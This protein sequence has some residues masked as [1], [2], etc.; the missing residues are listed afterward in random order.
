MKPH[1]Q[2]EFRC[3]FPLPVTYDSS[4]NRLKE[5]LND[6]QGTLTKTLSF[7]YDALNRPNRVTYPD[8][9]YS[10]YSYDVLGNR[11]SL[12]DPKDNTQTYIYDSLGRLTDVIQPGG[13]TTTYGH[14]APRW[15]ASFTDGNG[16]TTTYQYDD[17]GHLYEEISPDTGSTAYQYDPAG[18]MNLKTDARGITINYHY[19]AL[20][21]LI[22]I[23]YPTE[24]DVV[25][26]Y[27]TCTNGK[28][29]LCQVI[30]QA[31]TTTFTYSLKG[32]LV[33][34]DRLI[35][36]VNYITEYQYDDNGNLEVLTYPGGRTV[37]YAYDNADQ[38]T[39]VWTIPAG[40]MQE[41]VAS[42]IT[43]KPFGPIS[44]LIYGNGLPR[45]VSYDLLY[46]VVGIQTGAIQDLTYG[47]DPNDNVETIADNLNPGNNK[48]FS[49][50]PLNRL[51]GATGPWGALSLGYDN[52]GN[53]QTYTD[54]LGTTNYTYQGGTNLLT[55]LSGATSATFTYDNAGNMKTE[56]SRQY[57]Y[58]ENGDLSNVTD[59][60]S[61][62]DYT[63][64]AS[65]QRTTKTN[66]GGTTV[67][68]YDARELLVAETLPDGTVQSEYIYLGEQPLAKAI[69]GELH[70]IHTDHLV[71]PVMMTDSSGATTWSLEKR[72]FGDGEN[73]TGSEDLDIRFPGQYVDQDSGLHYNHYRYYEPSTGRYTQPDP[74]GMRGDWTLYAYVK[75]NPLLYSDPQGLQETLPRTKPERP[76][77]EP[78]APAP[79]GGW[80]RFRECWSKPNYGT[81]WWD[82]YL[83][84]SWGKGE[85]WGEPTTPGAAGHAAA[86][87]GDKYT[88]TYW[89][90][91]DLPFKK[92]EG[93]NKF[94]EIDWPKLDPDMQYFKDWCNAKTGKTGIYRGFCSGEISFK[95]RAVICACCK[96]D[97]D[98]GKK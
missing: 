35:L 27:D 22:S 52:V 33:Q 78:N 46:R 56:N 24:T 66:S 29:R 1:F 68:H 62:G 14:D 19:D 75:S 95:G 98:K 69:G 65:S 32:E 94:G 25:Y 72:P 9:T 43:H 84:G 48:T 80:R 54:D 81:S 41:A 31:G 23:D 47:R 17:T 51:V 96:W 7:Q 57:F 82:L 86:L 44:S 76:G 26:T 18:N 73:I 34:E 70:F 21:R 6:P 83:Q 40:G 36:G 30:D 67:F 92:F 13:I 77:T 97:C 60:V 93:S 3:S 88:P 89:C 64:N 10:E 58:N 53:R 90:D 37:T 71:T 45:S 63:H 91:F 79:R 49:Y 42:N 85:Q 28:G 38:I 61:L 87:C 11:T 74:L 5:D 8:N 4:G 55:A 12:K 20:N 39:T 2:A 59:G 16:N 50:D 15:L